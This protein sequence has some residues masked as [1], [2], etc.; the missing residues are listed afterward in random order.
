MNAVA[1]LAT[2]LLARMPLALDPLAPYRA[3]EVEVAALLTVAFSCGWLSAVT[4][5]LPP[6]LTEESLMDAWLV[7]GRG[8][9][10]IWVPSR[11]LMVSRAKPVNDWPN[12]QPSALKAMEGPAAT[13]D[14]SAVSVPGASVALRSEWAVNGGSRLLRRS[15][16]RR[17]HWW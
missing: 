9:S 12:V 15:G 5:R 6:A 2:L 10:P 17:C 7:T 13:P 16:W 14:V 4:E 8:E 1:W 3:E 11:V